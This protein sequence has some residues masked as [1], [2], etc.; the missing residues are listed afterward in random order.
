VPSLLR[1]FA[2]AGSAALLATAS[3]AAAELAKFA[4]KPIAINGNS[5][6][7]AT[8][9]N[10]AG[11]IV[12]ALFDANGTETGMQISG[13]TATALPNP[14]EPFTTFFPRLIDD[15]GD[16]LGYSNDPALGLTDMFLLQSG[17][18]NTAYTYAVIEPG[19]ATGV[20]PLPM[21]LTRNL[22]VSFNTILTLSAP[23]A[24]H[25][26]RPP[27]FQN[28][29]QQD[30]YTQINSINSAG[31][32]AGIAF[33][34][35]GPSAVYTGKGTAFTTITP[36]NAKS[37][38]GGYINDANI[39]AGS[40][41]DAANAWHG[42]TYAGGTVTTFDMPEANSRVTVTGINRAGRVVGVYTDSTGAQ[43]AFLWNGSTV[44]SFGKYRAGHVVVTAIGNKGGM[45]VSEQDPRTG[46][47]RS[48]SVA[49]RGQGC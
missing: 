41:V 24:T 12:G 4:I 3:G 43:H 28:V 6:F 21:G 14:G 26:G 16:I 9:I 13:G 15:S 22:K 17:M 33:S 31:I 25:Y 47:Y 46:V 30:Q 7:N 35:S 11:T 40:F 34:Q 32:V 37:V 23:V 38:M 49:C 20:P 2:L 5:D 48:E 39:V 8:A 44:Y 29:P 42:F 19:N 10:A 45:V 36:P 27:H 18:F 1:A